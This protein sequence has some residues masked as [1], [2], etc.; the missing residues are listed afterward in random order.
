MYTKIK[1]KAGETLIEW[2]DSSEKESVTHSLN[3]HQEPRPEFLAAFHAL[4][5]VALEICDL[6]AMYARELKVSGVTLTQHDTMGRGC[7]ITLLKKVRSSDS[8]LVLN[9]PFVTEYKGDGQTEG[10]L[11]HEGVIALERL[12]EEAARYVK[13]E[14]AQQDLFPEKAA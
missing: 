14:R 4:A 12:E 5:E 8:P 7:V 2:Q 1:H 6:P 10:G 3:S 13:G 9:T 11:Y